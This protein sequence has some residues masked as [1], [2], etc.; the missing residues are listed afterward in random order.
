MTQ[1]NFTS[2]KQELRAETFDIPERF[3]NCGFKNFNQTKENIDAYNK[4]LEFLNTQKSLIMYGNVGSGKTHL[5]IAIMKNLK[6]IE[7]EVKLRTDLYKGEKNIKTTK[8]FNV[9]RS[10]FLV[11][12]EFFRKLNDC[13]VN[14]E[15][16]QKVIDRY[17]TE[18]DLVVLDDLGIF[19]WSN[20]KQENLYLF[21]NRAYLNNKRIIITTNFTPLELK[22][23]DERITSRLKEMGDF[24]EFNGKDYR[25]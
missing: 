22:K 9:A 3:K 17:L 13:A 15:S 11:V 14:H 20:A 16:K 25:K 18:N 1:M 19:N 10:Q 8:V 21:I 23:K 12:D 24:I 6:P 4:C 5:A 7:R 2:S